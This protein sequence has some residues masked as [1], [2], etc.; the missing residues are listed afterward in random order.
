MNV[1]VSR[2]QNQDLGKHGHEADDEFD[3]SGM[4]RGIGHHK[5]HIDHEDSA[6]RKSGFLKK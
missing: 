5:H 6:P 3:S 1:G 4:M 2:G